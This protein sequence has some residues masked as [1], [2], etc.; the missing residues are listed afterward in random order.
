MLRWIVNLKRALF[1]DK[2]RENKLALRTKLVLRAQEELG[3]KFPREYF[4]YLVDPPENVWVW[5]G[6]D[7]GIGALEPINEAAGEL[8]IEDGSECEL[9]P[10]DLVIWMHQGY[11]FIFIPTDQ[12]DD[13]PVFFY[14]EGPPRTISPNA[15]R[16]EKIHDRLSEMI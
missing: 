10:T 9:K 8:L 16:F 15:G 11:Q 6:H 14:T 4:E 2:G 7:H 12:G 3:V 13:P 1:R 5:D